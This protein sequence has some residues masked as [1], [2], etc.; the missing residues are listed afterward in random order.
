M[1]K[2]G[3]IVKIVPNVYGTDGCLL[4][5]EIGVITKIIKPNWYKIFVTFTN[6]SGKLV[7]KHIPINE[8]QL[9]VNKG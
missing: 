3:D 1:F 4:L 7:K 9:I 2:P 6:I 5:G 8:N